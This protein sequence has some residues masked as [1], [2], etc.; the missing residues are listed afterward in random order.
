MS[1]RQNMI[2]EIMMYRVSQELQFKEMRSPSAVG[3]PR[4]SVLGLALARVSVLDY[5]ST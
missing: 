3:Y 1:I 2:E 4:L 5:L